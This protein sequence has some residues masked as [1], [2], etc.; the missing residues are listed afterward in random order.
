M[1]QMGPLPWALTFDTDRYV[2]GWDGALGLLPVALAGAW[3][4]ALLHRR[5][6]GL[7]VCATLAALLPLSAMQ[8]A[9]YVHPALVL[10]LPALLAALQG[11][12]ARRA[13]VLVVALCLGNLALQANAGWMLRTGAVKQSVLALG[14]DEPLFRHYA[15]ERV[16]AERIR[17]RA[18]ARGPV[19]LLSQ[20]FHAEFAGRGRDV[21][22]YAP[23]ME[24][25]ARQA[26]KD[27]SGRRWAAFL[28]DEGIAEVILDP[29]TLTP[30]QRAGL[31]RLGAR[32][33]AVAGNAE[34]WRIPPQETP[35]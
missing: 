15:P 29:A 30:A 17:G 16:L 2:E 34:W 1:N 27:R 20:P 26:N 6:R 24:A 9:R 12:P 35:R 23:R 10:L 14:R 3:L 7:A 28:R 5:S 21:A 32:R 4:V 19:L 33:E 11:L 13:S 8:Y 18:D 31:S 22:W 25:A